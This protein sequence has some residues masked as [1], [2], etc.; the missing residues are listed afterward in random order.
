MYSPFARDLT[1]GV[2]VCDSFGP[3]VGATRLIRSGAESG[4]P[5][6]ASRSSSG[7][8]G[9]DRGRSGQI[10]VDGM[11]GS[12][13]VSVRGPWPRSV[14][15]RANLRYCVASPKAVSPSASGVPA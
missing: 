14:Q 9:A 13:R 6:R 12:G 5:A 2:S 15:R 1:H 7:Q 4:A 10:G 11:A 8:I 3:A